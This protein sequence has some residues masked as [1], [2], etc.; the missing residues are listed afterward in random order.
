M[1]KENIEFYCKLCCSD[2]EDAIRRKNPKL[3]A[4]DPITFSFGF[5]VG[6]GV[7]NIRYCPFCST[8]MPASLSD[9]Y[10]DEL[11]QLLGKE[12]YNVEQDEIPEEFKT[13]E[14]WIK[15]GLYKGMYSGKMKFFCCA[16]MDRAVWDTPEV[17]NPY[18][19]PK[20]FIYEPVERLFGYTLD[21][22]KVIHPIEYCPFCGVKL[23]TW[24]GGEN[25]EYNIELEKVLGRKGYEA[26]FYYKEDGVFKECP[27]IDRTKVPEEF[28][29]DEWWI[30]RGL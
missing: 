20:I 12:Y 18:D 13:D 17:D 21:K 4:Y 3:L 15:R 23:P 16:E 26:L 2:L 27:V 10:H 30:K 14:W 19:D 9:K 24:L 7:L 8:K 11:T 6:S 22:E 25:D 28:K 1:K 5:E 29:T